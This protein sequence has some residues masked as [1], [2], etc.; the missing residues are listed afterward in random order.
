MIRDFIV[1]WFVENGSLSKEQIDESMDKNYLEMGIVDS[2]GFLRLISACE[3][4][5]G[6]E[7]MDDD[8]ANDQIFTINGMIG[9]ME[10]KSKSN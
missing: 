7:F 2:F 3:E 8:F 9:I 10:E 6:L 4:D 5:L 1:K